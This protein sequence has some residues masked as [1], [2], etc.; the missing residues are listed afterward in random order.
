LA[1]LAVESH[2]QAIVWFLDAS[3][4]LPISATTVVA[5][6]GR[7]ATRRSGRILDAGMVGIDVRPRRALP[8]QAGLASIAE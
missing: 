2:R 7:H 5:I 4:G 3:N 8:A 6:N 1:P